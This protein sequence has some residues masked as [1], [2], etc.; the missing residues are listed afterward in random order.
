MSDYISWFI[1]GEARNIEV[2]GHPQ[3]HVVER[4][5]FPNVY[6]A[7]IVMILAS[8]IHSYIRIQMSVLYYVPVLHLHHGRPANCTPHVTDSAIPTR[9]LPI[10][11]DQ[12]RN[13]GRISP[14]RMVRQSASAASSAS[15]FK[16]GVQGLLCS[17]L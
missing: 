11:F 15:R 16:H 2:G 3:R 4:I 7:G 10:P 5:K 1:S 17:R 12:D 8:R 6:A 13:K 14:K 9:R